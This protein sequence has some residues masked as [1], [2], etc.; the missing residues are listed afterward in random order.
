VCISRAQKKQDTGPED[1]HK[2]SANGLPGGFPLVLGFEDLTVYHS[3][4][5]T[6]VDSTEDPVCL[7]GQRSSTRRSR[8]LPHI[9][10]GARKDLL[11]AAYGWV[12]GVH[13]FPC[14][15]P[16]AFSRQVLPHRPGWLGTC[17][18]H[19]AGLGLTEIFLSKLPEYRE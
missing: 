9:W 8:G 7:A 6:F 2:D 14:F 19:E 11:V 17:Y 4:T 12:W 10:C 15:V 16:F 13:L 1:R 3:G 18:E 5:M